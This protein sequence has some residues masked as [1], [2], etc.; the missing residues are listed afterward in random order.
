MKLVPGRVMVFG[1]FDVFHKGHEYYINEAVKFSKDSDIVI[2]VARD[3]TVRRLKDFLKNSEEDRLRVLSDY[4]P[5]ATVVLGD[6]EDVMKVV[7]EYMPGTV[8]FGYD[9]N[10][11]GNEL[12]ENFPEIEVLRIGAHEP[13]KYK[14]SKIGA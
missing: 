7:R 11:F 9:Q 8:C 1:T 5:E 3:V 4:F 6:E 13:E 12:E 14:S 2:V 10:S